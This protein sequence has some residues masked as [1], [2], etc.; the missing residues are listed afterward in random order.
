MLGYIS[1]GL[2]RAKNSGIAV[3]IGHTWSPELAPLLEQQFP[4]LTEQGYTIKTVSDI[5]K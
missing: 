4:L 3:M 2:T 1:N 5:L